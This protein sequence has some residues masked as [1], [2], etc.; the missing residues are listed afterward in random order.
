MAALPNPFQRYLLVQKKYDEKIMVVLERAAV[1]LRRRIADLKTGTTFSSSVRARQLNLALIAIRQEQIAMFQSIGQFI[2]EGQIA[3]AT[4]AIEDM[5]ELAEVAYSSLSASAADD[6][7]DSLRFTAQAGIET[8]YSHTPRELSARLYRNGA[9]STEH[10]GRLIKSGLAQGLSAREMAKTVYQFVSPTVPGGAAYVAMRLARTE[11][12]NAFHNQQIAGMDAP[13]VEG[14]KWTL[15]RSHKVPD[16][17]NTYAE[18]DQYD[19]G[20]GV[21]PPGKV[22]SKP[23]PQCFCHLVL[24]S[25]DPEVF[26]ADVRTGKYD[27]ELRRRY[28]ANLDSLKAPTQLT[29]PTTSKVPSLPSNP[30]R[31]NEHLDRANKVTGLSRNT[32]GAALERQAQLAPAAMTHMRQVRV[33]RGAELD[34]FRAEQGPNAVAAYHPS[35]GITLTPEALT[36]KGQAAAKQGVRSGWYSRCDANVSGAESVIAHET[37]H[38]MDEMISRLP[39]AAKKEIW[40]T[41]AKELS[42]PRPLFYDSD[43]LDRWVKKHN[44]VLVKQVSGYGAKDSGEI[45][46]EVWHEY[47]TATH[48]RPHMTRVG[49]IIQRRAE[50]GAR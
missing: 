42:L 27:D 11:I 18:T 15:S 39:V 7:I 12:N 16:A 2:T 35:R 20:A 50:E 6:L 26:A 23:H 21:F 44:D 10:I 47:S 9:E 25:V 13:G 40:D 31:V 34:D 48:A 19:M 33:V 32:V 24:V 4:E 41:L 46:A 37:G 14:A 28:K 45:I 43:S 17:C 38:H 22:P 5:A 1:D 3:A 8:L 36:A 30:A 29:K 49:Q